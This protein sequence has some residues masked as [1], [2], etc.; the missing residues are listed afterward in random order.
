MGIIFKIVDYDSK[1]RSLEKPPIILNDLPDVTKEDK[2]TINKILQQKFTDDIMSVV[3]RCSCGKIEGEFNIGIICEYCNTEVIRES[4][5]LECKVWVR[6]PY[7]IDGFFHPLIWSMLKKRFTKDGFS[8]INYIA[9]VSYGKTAINEKTLPYV[10]LLKSLGIGRGYQYF[11]NNYIEIVEKLDSLSLFPKP[12]DGDPGV[13]GLIMANKDRIISQ[14]LPIINKTLMVIE[15]KGKTTYID[16]ILYK[17]LDAAQIL[18]NVDSAIK[19]FSISKKENRTVKTVDGL[20]NFYQLIYTEQLQGKPSLIRKNNLGTRADFS[21]RC[22]ITSITDPEPENTIHIP[23]SV[24]ITSLR[25]HIVNKLIKRKFGL[26]A[27]FDF[28][29]MNAHKYNQILD[30]IFN[31]LID[32]SGGIHV[33]AQRNPTLGRGS[34]QLFRVSKIKTDPTDH[35]A[36]I[37]INNVVGFNADFDGDQMN[38]TFMLDEVMVQYMR[39]FEPHNSVF[40]MTDYK[41][42]SGNYSMPKPVVANIANWLES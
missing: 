40:N 15:D 22:V 38:F 26:Y 41:E 6:A 24:A 37:N 7:G 13:L 9:D 34:I 19:N 20:A 36:S 21:A 32:E 17:G 11:I 12:K 14:F 35:T 3:P 16:P 23:W 31:E 33:I 10:E 30:E 42:I 25:L 5:V 18:I 2:E 27:I 39:V 29:Y 8:F 28:L 1:F 4:E